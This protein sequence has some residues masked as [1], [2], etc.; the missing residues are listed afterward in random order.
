VNIVLENWVEASEKSALALEAMRDAERLAFHMDVEALM[1]QVVDIQRHL[2][3]QV[4]RWQSAIA[5]GT[6]AYD[7]ATARAFHQLYRRL[8]GTALRTA[9][10]GRRVEAWGLEL[11][12]K[13]AFL[14][15]WRELRAIESF[16]LERVAESLTQVRRGGAKALG[17]FA[18]ELSRDCIRQS[19]RV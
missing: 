19:C 3:A 17:E 18:D 11:R 14:A 15:A 8:E 7:D 6:M 9:Q 1:E 12:G 16:S 10:L 2:D 5:A 13:P 4:E